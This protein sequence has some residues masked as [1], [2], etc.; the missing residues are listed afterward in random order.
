MPTSTNGAIFRK[1]REHAWKGDIDWS[2]TTAQTFKMHAI[3]A[4]QLP[5]GL[6]YTITNV[7]SDGT[8]LGPGGNPRCKVTILGSHSF[9][10]GDFVHIFG[11]EGVTGANGTWE[12]AAVSGNDLTLDYSVFSGAYSGHLG[13]CVGVA[14]QSERRPPERGNRPGRMGQGVA[15]W[16][17]P[18]PRG[19]LVASLPVSSTRL[20][21]L[22]S[23]PR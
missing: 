11:V 10:V 1:A 13:R 23:A 3:D 7:M 2:A 22:R 19:Y 21:G 18:K 5:A 6:A 4:S 17:D 14:V 16:A 9:A 8:V 15:P 12:L 20:A